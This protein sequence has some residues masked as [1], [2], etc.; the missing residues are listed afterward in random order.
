MLCLYH[1]IY[2]WFVAWNL[3]ISPCFSCRCF[4]RE[5]LYASDRS[6]QDAQL[7]EDV[8][9]FGAGDKIGAGVWFNLMLGKDVVKRCGKRCEKRLYS[10]VHNSSNYFLMRE[11]SSPFRFRIGFQ[12][13]WH[14]DLL[15]LLHS[16]PND[17]LFRIARFPKRDSMDS[18]SLQISIWP[19]KSSLKVSQPK[20]HHSFSWTAFNRYADMPPSE[21]GK[22][23]PATTQPLRN[24]LDNTILELLW[25]KIFGWRELHWLLCCFFFFSLPWCYLSMGLP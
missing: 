24:S 7:G 11:F 18:N 22:K 16:K 14:S 21:S 20:S 10:L 19:P 1:C 6:L 13:W 5:V 15:Q 8:A 12:M 9:G 2:L 3:E 4:S 23:Q 17:F 25:N